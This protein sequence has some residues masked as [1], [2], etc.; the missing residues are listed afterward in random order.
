MN[1]CRPAILLLLANPVLADV[2]VRE[3]VLRTTKHEQLIVSIEHERSAK[4][5]FEKVT[6]NFFRVSDGVRTLVRRETRGVGFSSETVTSVGNFLN[7]GRKQILVFMVHGGTFGEVLDFDGR[8]VKTVYD[9]SE[10]GPRVWLRCVEHHGQQLIEEGWT[11]SGYSE[12][13]FSIHRKSDNLI[14]RLMR[15]DNTQW[16]PLKF[17]FANG[18]PVPLHAQ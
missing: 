16:V 13:G 2:T 15:W 5:G 7:N 9:S 4:T 18:Q 12:P 11:P 8:Q 10:Y 17:R 14:V 1:L 3:Q 6:C